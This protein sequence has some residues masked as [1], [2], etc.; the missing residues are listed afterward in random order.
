MK[1]SASK[2]KASQSRSKGEIPSRSRRRERL[3]CFK[4]K[5]SYLL[6]SDAELFIYLIQCIRFGSRKVRR[7]NRALIV[8]LEVGFSISAVKAQGH[9]ATI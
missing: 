4:L 8:L 3:S 9:P 5:Q 2:S 7:L 6:D 1:R